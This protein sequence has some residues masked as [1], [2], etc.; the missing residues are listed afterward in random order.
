MT[1]AFDVTSGIPR[2]TQSGTDTGLSGIATAITAQAT[3]ARSTAYTVAQ[4]VKPPTPTGFWYRCSTAGTTAAAAPTYGT[5]LGGTTTDGTS[6]W[7]AFKAPDIQ[8]LGTTN[9]YYMPDVR[10]AI[11]GTLTNANPQ[12]QNFTCYDLIIYTGNFTS[13]AWASDGVTPLWDGLHFAAVRT[14][15]SGADGTTMSL[16]AG[17]Q[18]TFIGGEVQCAGGVT[19]DSGTTPRSYLTRWRNTKEW[20]ASSSRFRSYTT[21]LIFQNVETYDFAYDLF[22]MPT[23]APSI[24]ARGSEYVYQYVGAGAGG[25][26]AKFVA[27]NLENPDGTYDFDNYFGGWVE[28]YNCKAGAALK[29]YSQYPNSSIWVKHCVPL[30]QDV[31][32]T[33]KDTAGAVVQDVRFTATESPTNSPTVTFTTASSLKTWDFRTPLSYQTTTNASGIATSTPVLN[34]WYW[35]TS[36]KQSLRFPSSTAVYQGRAYNFKTLNVSALL[37]ASTAVQVSAGMIS[38]D[39]AT[40]I[41]ESA[42]L[43]LTG[44]T[45]TPSG[46]TGGSIVISSNHTLQDVWNYYRAWISAFA[47]IASNDSWTALNSTLNSGD[48]TLTVNSGVTLSSSSNFTTYKTNG[49]ITNNGTIDAVAQDSS[50]SSSQITISNLINSSL[51]VS[52]NTNSQYYLGTNITGSVTKFTDPSA[53]GTWNWYSERYGYLRLSGSFLPALGG[54]N[55]ITAVWAPDPY[56]TQTNSTTV[57][58][59]TSIS[60]LNQL[61]DYESY[62]K[63]TSSGITHTLLTRNGTLLD[64]GATNLVIDA[65]ALSVWDYNSI[66]NTITINS[67]TLVATSKYTK[68]K[69]ST[70]T[71]RNGA[72]ATCL[73]ETSTGP[74]AKLNFSGLSSSSIYLAN[75]TG[76]QQDFQSNKSG[77]YSEYIV[78]GSSGTWSWIA[79]RYGYTRQANTFTPAIG[80][81]FNITTNWLS[82]IYISELVQ[83]TVSAYTSISDL[84]Q[85]YDYE[86]YWRTTNSGITHTLLTRNGTLLDFGA[87]NLVFDK[88]ASTVWSYNSGSD[89]LT[90][91]STIMAASSQ[92]AKIKT[93]GTITFSNG[94]TATCL[95]ET[96]TGASTIIK[97]TNVSANTT[98]AVWNSS[99]TLLY[100]YITSTS[101]TF[102]Y[103]VAPGIT[104]TYYYATEKYSYQRTDGQKSIGTGG[105][106]TITV[107]YSLDPNIDVVSQATVSAYLS[108]TTPNK[109]YD[110]GAYMRTLQPKWILTDKNGTAVDL[111]TTNLVVDKTAVD[112]WVYDELTNTLTIKSS[113][114]VR[115]P[116]LFTMRTSG[117]ITK[118]H[119]ADISVAF[120]DAL[121]ARATITGLDPENFGI[122]WNTRYKLST[123]S[124]WTIITGTGNSQ[125]ILVADG[126]YNIE[127]RAAGYDWVS[128]NLDTTISLVA[129]MALKYHVAQDQSPQ[130]LKPYN[131]TLESIFQFDPVAQKVEVINTTGVIIQP[132][133]AE[134]YRAIQRI[135]LE[136]SLVWLWT[137]PITSSPSTQTVLIPASNPISFYLSED[138]TQTVKITCPVIITETGTSAD[139]RVKGNTSGYSIVLGS[140]ATAESAGLKDAIITAILGSLGGEGFNTTTDSLVQVSSRLTDLPAALLSTELA[141]VKTVEENLIET[142]NLVKIA[143]IETQK[144]N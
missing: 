122:T 85:L 6:V 109:I 98:L 96:S 24:K 83:S 102:N 3:V 8:T 45:L 2:I 143:A 32:I 86:A 20:G 16:Q 129:D 22:R 132:S 57:S 141:N 35:Q 19:F 53:T 90:V 82:D 103:Y 33:A 106:E 119:A 81:D 123:E 89:T 36:F 18:F 48:W 28:L 115:G 97:F 43:A 39:T 11:N 88:T 94:A 1:W 73:Y 66:T 74:S 67:S 71:F 14:S 44:I 78:P 134:L 121:G 108:I 13:G 4:M 29:V 133:F 116:S 128:E 25:A 42:A 105:V 114:I 118:V 100:N 15:A 10:M 34:V 23:V 140:S 40:T 135:E 31:T 92:F 139:D 127:T 77:T 61:Y 26:D 99:G 38:L 46:A 65:T 124:T 37:G 21:N 131:F 62:W 58:A 101:G 59:Y 130:Y 41:T 30:Y 137:N 56:I 126:I 55:N 51:Y 68:L 144:V 120:K 12:Q 80:G 63:T 70:I 87:T 75:D 49:I 95:Y 110:Y 84:N 17:G 112:V 93:T 64:F 7:T 5:T 60:D 79:E 50:G 104:D 111:L 52:T 91:K 72:T 27:S 125:A 113:D 107:L 76:V 54:I 117:L 142:T 136:P 138:S 69:A 9:H 47:N